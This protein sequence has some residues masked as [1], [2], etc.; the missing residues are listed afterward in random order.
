MFFL[1]IKGPSTSRKG[2]PRVGFNESSERTKRRKVDDLV[3]S[4]CP[5]QL[6]RAVQRVSSPTPETSI[7][8]EKALALLID[9]D[10]S[11]RQYEN[12]R[13]VVN[14]VHKNCFPSYY[15]LQ[16]AKKKYI[17]ENISIS[18]TSVKIPL[19]NFLNM[20][21]KSLL[22]LNDFETQNDVVLEI[23]WGFDGSSGHSNYK[24]K[25]NDPNSRDEYLF[26]ASF[27]PLR[28]L[29]WATENSLWNNLKHSSIRY[30]RPIC[31]YMEKE[32]SDLVK[33][34]RAIIEEEIDNLQTFD[35]VSDKKNLTVHFDMRL[36]M[37]DG[38][39]LNVL[40]DN[41][42]SSSCF[43][44]GAKPTEMNLIQVFER[45]LKK[46]EE[47]HKHGLSTLHAWIKFFECILHIAYRLPLKIWRVSKNDDKQILNQRK[48]K[49][50]EDFKKELGLN[51]DKVKTGFGT[52]ND[53]NTARRFFSNIDVSSSI[54]QVDPSLIKNFS[55]ILKTIS[56][57]KTINII[58]FQ[59]LLRETWNL[60]VQKYSWYCMPVTVH[61]ILVHGAEFIKNSKIPVG[62]LSE[63]AIEATHKVFRKTRLNHTRKNSRTNTNKDLIERMVL[64]SE[65]KLSIHRKEDK[66]S[67][68]SCEEI[69]DFIIEENNIYAD[70]QENLINQLEESDSDE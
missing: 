26:V 19:Q 46:R 69:N 52:T 33:T 28:F 57:S 44:C 10:L 34:T 31:Y 38:A 23:K 11:Y 60:Y 40:A 68:R 5:E 39:V 59:Q 32:N 43:V 3:R 15:S 58:N 54:T 20:T 47:L 56:S 21:A 36:T 29:D 55:L 62:M 22:D 27:V 49:I 41:K 25:F 4:T 6:R 24:Q 48:S 13:T 64:Q 66:I 18:E 51:V 1:F 61:K 30:C 16:K 17:P 9:N 7:S 14:D 12:M 8:V 50:Q 35:Y 70:N 67:K 37:V 65:P 63:E 2:R 42:S 53:G 45:D